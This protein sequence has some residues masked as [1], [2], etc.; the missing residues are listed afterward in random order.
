ME[1]KVV[2]RPFGFRR[3]VVPALLLS[4]I[5]LPVRAQT[6]GGDV[7]AGEVSASGG[8]G[9]SESVGTQLPTPQQ[10]FQSPETVRVIDPSQTQ[11]VGPAAGAAQ[12]FALTPGAYVNGYGNT[13]ATKYTVS[14]DGVGQGWGGYG[15]YTGG[16]SLM[17]TLDGVPMVDPATGLWASASIPSMAMFQGMTA[18]YGPGDAA[19]RWYD[20]IGG[21]IEFTP[22][23][24]SKTAGGMIN[25]TY[26]SYNEQILDFALNSGEHNGWATILAGSF[27]TGQSYRVG[28]DGFNNP[29]NDYALYT[30]TV[31]TFDHGDVA[32]GAY[33]ARSAA[34]RPQV[35]PT[36]LNG[37]ITLNGV[38]PTGAIN[39]GQL[40]SQPTSGFYS[41][42]PYDSYN[43]FDVNQLWTVYGKA[44]YELDD[45]TALHNLAYYVRE[46]RLHAR[47]N[48]A[49]PQGAA[50]VEEYNNPY[51]YWF[52]DKLSVTKNWWINT[53]D[54]GGFVQQSEYNTSN[55]FYNQTAPY[56]GSNTAPNA[57]YRS[58][59]FDQLDTGIYLQ[60]DI[61][62]LSNLHITPGIRFVSFSTSYSDA[63]ASNFPNATGHNQGALGN[64]LP[65]YQ[66]RTFT[67]PEPS[68]EVSYTPLKWLNLYASYE[69][70]YKTPQVGGG[71]GLYQAI[72][73]QFAQLA[74]SQEYQIGFKMFT[75]Q[76]DLFLH[77]ADFGANY[78]YL[79]YSKQTIDTTL[80]N[81][82]TLTS[83]GSSYY[84]GVNLF[85][86]DNPFL[87]LHT[88]AN[89]SFVNAVYSSYTNGN[90]PPTSYA[91]SHVPYVPNATLN[92][93]ADYKFLTRGVVVDPWALFQYSGSQYIFNNVTVAPSSQQLSG[94]STLNLGVN[95]TV[96]VTLYG[97][98]RDINFSLAMLNATNN[99][100]NAY[101]YLS[102]GGYYGTTTNGYGLAY[103][104]APMTLYGSVGVTF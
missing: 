37:Q 22:L 9:G 66:S 88:F 41:T 86:D 8:G 55:A 74:H 5:A 34:Y 92:I 30:K 23:Q 57:H 40:Y 14:L 60:D 59:I 17:V 4:G 71:G 94:F 52:G 44:N 1:R 103:P 11:T 75:D 70:A 43:K 33:F 85:A 67:A 81:G 62:P 64:G 91:G 63:S 45:T 84:Q 95:V 98:E 90:F 26:G 10:V 24:P 76:P 48:D 25:M 83:F 39:P 27:G 78:F 93:G 97:K 79:R 15:G 69:E 20:N 56:F 65:G 12:S 49:Y 99:K 53:F 80:A 54:A 36:Q 61:H 31:K 68:V 47:T 72:P 16:A 28:P 35:T 87:Q 58:G 82:N 104:G 46:D 77:N 19:D 89:A 73:A 96:P 29:W 13:G 42:P 2:V 18:T 3:L 102:S 6:A 32:I 51:S 7:N 21:S 38:S 50:N 100:Y 101:L